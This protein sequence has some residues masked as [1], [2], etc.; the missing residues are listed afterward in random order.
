MKTKSLIQ[1]LIEAGYPKEEIH[2]HES[3]LYIFVTPLTT[4]VLKDWAKANGWDVTRVEKT[5]MLFGTFKDNVT[6]KMMYD[7]AFQY[8]IQPE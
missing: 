6:G 5:S 3:D 7:I 1:M 2:H 8:T 4:K